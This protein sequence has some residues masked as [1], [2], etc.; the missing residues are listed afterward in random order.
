MEKEAFIGKLG[1]IYEGKNI[2]NNNLLIISINLFKLYNYYINEDNLSE[3]IKEIINQI[4][5]NIKKCNNNNIYDIYI[6]EN[7][8]NFVIDKY[9]LNFEEYFK[10]NQDFNFENINSFIIQLNQYLKIFRNLDMNLNYIHPK[11]IFVFKEN[12]TIKY[13]FLF[14]YNKIILDDDKILLS[15]EIK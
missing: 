1:I 8:I 10:N 2:K 4:I 14:Y 7:S 9:N 15:P 11:N 13:Q 5:N 3:R 12:E 6:E